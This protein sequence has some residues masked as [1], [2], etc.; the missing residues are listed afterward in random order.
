ISCPEPAE[1]PPLPET[2]EDLPVR[3][4]YLHLLDQPRATLEELLAA[5]LGARI[6]VE[7]GVAWLAEEGLVKE[8][9]RIAAEERSPAGQL[10]RRILLLYSEAAWSSLIEALSSDAAE[11]DN[12][13]WVGLRDLLEQR[14][15]GTGWITFGDQP[16]TLH[17]QELSASSFSRLKLVLS[18]CDGLL[19]WVGEGILPEAEEELI[20]SLLPPVANRSALL[21]A[22]QG[23]PQRLRDEVSARPDWQ[24]LEQPEERLSRL[25][26][27]LEPTA[28][29]D[30]P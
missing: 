10:P 17:V 16:V 12:P 15:G 11:A 6:E 30:S 1:L 21:L 2:L 7:L 27:R 29:G 22:P 8:V 20:Q 23:L 3:D 9:D 14:R 5:G 24:L 18:I 26:L 13:G 28:S 4:L 25:L 19:V